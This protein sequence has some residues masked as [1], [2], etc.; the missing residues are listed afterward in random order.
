MSLRKFTKMYYNS[1][2]YDNSVE[3]GYQRPEAAMKLLRSLM[4]EWEKGREN[5]EWHWFWS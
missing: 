1:C 2:L 4:G 3:A 5:K